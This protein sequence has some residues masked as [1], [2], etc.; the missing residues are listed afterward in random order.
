MGTHSRAA[1]PAQE[2]TGL[3]PAMRWTLAGACAVAAV[4]VVVA[5]MLVFAPSD[6]TPSAGADAPEPIA[7]ST[8]G[9]LPSATP[10]DGSEVQP[11]SATHAPADGLPPLPTP[12]PLVAAPLPETAHARGALVEGFPTALAA[13]APDADVID[14]AVASS[15]SVMQVTLTARTDDPSEDVVAHYRDVWSQLGLSDAGG[16]AALAFADSFTSVTLAFTDGSG[17]GTV[18]SLHATLRTE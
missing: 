16:D 18:Y 10:V 11:P 3:S 1:A 12:T 6:A 9:P 2:R 8:A 13:P 15:G 17:T 4:G 7:T 14:S 5:V